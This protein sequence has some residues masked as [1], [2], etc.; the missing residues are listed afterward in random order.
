MNLGLFCTM[1][2]KRCEFN[3]II[4]RG[5]WKKRKGE[6]MQEGEHEGKKAGRGR[7]TLHKYGK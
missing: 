2:I 3:D 5:R 7:G 4:M 6:I 1:M